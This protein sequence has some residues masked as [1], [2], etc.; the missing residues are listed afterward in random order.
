MKKIIINL[1]ISAM[2]L[3]LLSGCSF[4]QPDNN[5]FVSKISK[6]TKLTETESIVL[7]ND[8]SSF[9]ND[10]YLPSQTM[11]YINATDTKSVFF[12]TIDTDLRSKG[13]GLTFEN[14]VKDVNFL[15]WH[16]SELSDNILRATYNIDTSRVTKMYKRNEDNLSSYGSFTAINLKEKIAK[17]ELPKLSEVEEIKEEVIK[18]PLTGT[19]FARVL[20]IREHP[21]LKSKVIG[22]ITKGTIVEIDY[23]TINNNYPWAKLLNQDGYIS[24]KYVRY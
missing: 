7:A 9:I 24:N 12:K 19:V 4:N 13:Y 6:N 20:R 15:S 11:F 10:Y 8:F 3:F 23:T 17:E 16:I 2:S 22:S 14:D 18:V 21:S 1:S 5:Y